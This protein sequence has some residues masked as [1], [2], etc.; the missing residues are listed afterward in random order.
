MTQKKMFRITTAILAVLL[1]LCITTVCATEE[2]YAATQY[3]TAKT[4]CGYTGSIPVY[5]TA[6]TGTPL[7]CTVNGTTYNARLSP[8]TYAVYEGRSGNFYK[9]KWGSTSAYVSSTNGVMVESK[10]TGT[11]LLSSRKKVTLA[12]NAPWGGYLASGV[13]VTYTDQS[14]GKIKWGVYAPRQDAITNDDKWVNP[15][16]A[17]LSSL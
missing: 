16:Y 4:A 2:T 9:I 1:T 6:S 15:G 17:I 11:T 13:Y 10:G 3:I 7:T 14:A 12:Q 5:K 8:H